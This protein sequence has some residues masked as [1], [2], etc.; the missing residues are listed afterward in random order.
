[1]LPTMMP[2]R[3]SGRV[4]VRNTHGRDAPSVAPACSSL[5]STAV[6][7]QADGADHQRKRHDAGGQR[8]AGPAEGEDDAEGI[9]EKAADRPLRAEGQKQDIAGDHRWQDQRQVH[10][11]VQELLAGK[12]PARQREGDE[13]AERQTDHRRPERDLER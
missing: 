3:I 6:D 8:R 12:A 13:D 9:L 4:T 10:D 2:G 5:G 7:R 11:P 1:M